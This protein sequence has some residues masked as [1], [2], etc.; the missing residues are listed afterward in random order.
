MKEMRRSEPKEIHLTD[1]DRA[2]IQSDVERFLSAGN[3]IKQVEMGATSLDYGLTLSQQS[4]ARK[5]GKN[6]SAKTS[7]HRQR[8][9]MER[10]K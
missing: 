1:S 2:R 6:G 8:W 3:E 7:R 5:A 9:G 4:V 10:G